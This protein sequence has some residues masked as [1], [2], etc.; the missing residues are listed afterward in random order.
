MLRNE[1]CFLQF[2]S[3]FACKTVNIHCYLKKS[4]YVAPF[5]HY[6]C[7]YL[8]SSLLKFGLLKKKKNYPMLVIFH[9]SLVKMI[10]KNE[11]RMSVKK[12]K[13]TGTFILCYITDICYVI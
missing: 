4:K 3:V 11:I 1:D 10:I 12:N 5:D 2:A 7:V 8:K 13:T 9:T 6:F